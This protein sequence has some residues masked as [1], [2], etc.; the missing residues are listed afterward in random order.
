M[1]GSKRASRDFEVRFEYEKKLEEE[2]F[3]HV[4]KIA[5]PVSRSVERELRVAKECEEDFPV[6]IY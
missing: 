2:Q 4:W 5:T 3:S 1:L 6:R